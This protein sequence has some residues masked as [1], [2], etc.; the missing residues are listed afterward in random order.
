LFKREHFIRQPGEPTHSQF[1]FSQ[2]W[3]EQR[4]QFRMNA[5]GKEGKIAK[6]SL[7]VD[8][9]YEFS[10]PV[11]LLAGESLVTEGKRQVQV[12]DAKGN[13]RQTLTLDRDLPVM[14]P[15]KHK[16]TVDCQFSGDEKPILYF[17]VSGLS[18]EETVT[19]ALNR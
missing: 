7:Q 16:I 1:E 19:S 11:E 12:Y 3:K 17:Q 18:K 13:H 15:G 14:V 8:D 10:L 6:I 5:E 2:Q 4:L 9:Y